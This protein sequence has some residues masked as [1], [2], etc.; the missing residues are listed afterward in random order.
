MSKV[1]RIVER[2]VFPPAILLIAISIVSYSSLAFVFLTG[3]DESSLSAIVYILSAYTLTIQIARIVRIAKGSAPKLKENEKLAYLFDRNIRMLFTLSLSTGISALHGGFSIVTGL[4]GDFI[5]SLC[6]GIYYIL[7]A[8]IRFGLVKNVR[9]DEKEQNLDAPSFMMLSANILMIVVISIQMLESRV[10]SY[11][12]YMIYAVAAY[13]FYMIILSSVNLR[14]TSASSNRAV[15]LARSLSFSVALVSLFSLQLSMNKTFGSGA[16]FER[17]MN[18]AS[19]AV[20]S[21]LLLVISIFQLL[22]N[23]KKKKLPPEKERAS[24]V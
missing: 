11:P 16:V 14:K 13:T 8:V 17:I 22:E 12:G 21:L 3:R 2:V 24:D 18:I 15:K 23:N 5:F 1:G 20:V 4:M 6:S 9:V 19:G 10:K 7:L